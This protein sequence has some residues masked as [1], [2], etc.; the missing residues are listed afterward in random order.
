MSLTSDLIAMDDKNSYGVKK[1]GLSRS[2]YYKGQREKVKA[3]RRKLA[4][5]YD[6]GNI[7]TGYVLDPNHYIKLKNQRG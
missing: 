2:K 1:N 5:F 3:K 4:E 7:I 6:S